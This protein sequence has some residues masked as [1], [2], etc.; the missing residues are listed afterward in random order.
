VLPCRTIPLAVALLASVAPGATAQQ[1]TVATPEEVARAVLRADSAGD[2]ETV[3]RLAHPDALSRF[4]GRQV[5]QLRMLGT[6]G[7]PGADTPADDTVGMHA[8]DTV[9]AEAPVTDSMTPDSTVQARWQRIRREQQRFML[10][11]IFQAPDVDSLSRTSP[12]TVYARWVRGMQAR[13]RSDTTVQRPERPPYRVVGAV[14]ASDTL[15]YVVMERPLV[16][17]LGS[18]PELF[19]DLPRETHTAG[20]MVMRRHGRQ[21]RSMLD[22]VGESLGLAAGL[23]HGE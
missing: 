2:W 23:L 18:M 7:W 11:T 22:G 8:P 17:P 10:D 16:Q 13:S 5:F 20:I 1:P 14:K 19:R 9:G 4:R 15:A 12:D 3:L 21:W 6:P